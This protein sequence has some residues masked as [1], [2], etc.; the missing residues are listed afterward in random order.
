VSVM[1]APMTVPVKSR[2]TAE[3]RVFVGLIYRAMR[4]VAAAIKQR[5]GITILVEMTG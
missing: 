1:N 3:D 5:Y 4:M 2:P